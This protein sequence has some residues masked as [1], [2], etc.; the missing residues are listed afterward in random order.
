MV[1]A[2]QLVALVAVLCQAVAVLLVRRSFNGWLAPF[3]LVGTGSLALLLPLRGQGANRAWI[4]R[5]SGDRV[6]HALHQ[7]LGPTVLVVA[8]SMVLM[9]WVWNCSPGGDIASGERPGDLLDGDP[10]LLHPCRD[11]SDPARPRSPVPV[12]HRP[13]LGRGVGVCHDKSDGPTIKM[14]SLGGACQPP[15]RS[16]VRSPPHARSRILL[17][18]PF[19]TSVE[20]WA[21]PQKALHPGA[22]LSIPHGTQSSMRIT[23][24]ILVM[25][26]GISGRTVCS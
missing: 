22:G 14:H 15:S 1:A 24:S 11:Q 8:A 25:T 6:F 20:N 13:V 3:A 17:N 10:P 21:Q 4:P 19:W 5:L 23:A 2:H 9:F 18:E 26:V 12:V 16:L 7:I